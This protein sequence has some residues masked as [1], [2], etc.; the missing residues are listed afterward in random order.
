MTERRIMRIFRYEE[1]YLA[2][3]QTYVYETLPSLNGVFSGSGE[4]LERLLEKMRAAKRAR[5][6]ILIA[7]EPSEQRRQ[8]PLHRKD[9]A[10]L[11]RHFGM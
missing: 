10:Y 5:Y 1:S 3:T 6:K 2:D 4:D 7:K 11:I 8:Y 9:E